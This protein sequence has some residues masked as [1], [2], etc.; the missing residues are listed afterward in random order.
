MAWTNDYAGRCS[1]CRAA[2]PAGAGRV[3]RAGARASWEVWC[4]PCWSRA[5]IPLSLLGGVTVTLN[6]SFP[7]GCQVWWRGN[8]VIGHVY[9]NASTGTFVGATRVDFSTEDYPGGLQQVAEA[10]NAALRRT[11]EG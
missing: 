7:A 4:Q 8:E 1:Q 9:P 3:R 2:V 6:D 10:M 11:V 5:N